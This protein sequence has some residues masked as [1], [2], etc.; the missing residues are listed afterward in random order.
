MLHVLLALTVSPAL[1]DDIEGPPEE[2]PPGAQGDS[3]HAGPYC[4]PWRCTNDSECAPGFDCVEAGLCATNA[5]VSGGIEGS[6]WERIEVHGICSGRAGCAEG[7]CMTL[8]VCM[9][10]NSSP[11]VMVE[12]TMERPPT[13]TTVS[14]QTT[15]EEEEDESCSVVTPSFVVAIGIVA[16]VLAGLRRKRS[17]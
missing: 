13:A 12:P 7:Q 17:S 4:K 3:D 16:L 15:T 14:T 9:P 6:S 1:A 5:R 11:P 10:R 2:C 8:Q